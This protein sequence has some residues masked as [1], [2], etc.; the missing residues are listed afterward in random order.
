MYKISKRF[1]FSASHILDGLPQEHPCSRLHGHNY[2]ITIYL[3][4]EQLNSV[5]FVK[6]YRELDHVKRYIDEKLDHRH[7]NDILPF[8]PT[9]ENMAK[10]LYDVFKADIPELYAVEV[11]ETPKTTAVYEADNK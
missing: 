11:S 9:A 3:R 6:D 4:A 5:G 2:M 8:N 7:L 1:S 10:Y